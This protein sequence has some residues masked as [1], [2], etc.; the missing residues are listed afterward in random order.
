[1]DPLPLLYELRDLLA[2][3]ENDRKRIKALEGILRPMMRETGPLNINGLTTHVAQPRLLDRW[4]T[5]HLFLLSEKEP[6]IMKAHTATYTLAPV[7]FKL[8]NSRLRLKD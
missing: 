2:T 7:T 5:P 3:T 8:I 1:M 6:L 4:N